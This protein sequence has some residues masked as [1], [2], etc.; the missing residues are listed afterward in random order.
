[1]PFN[2]VE[3]VPQGW[4]ELVWPK[5]IKTEVRRCPGVKRNQHLP[6]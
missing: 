6:L 3:E 5:E 1:M 2:S 4:N